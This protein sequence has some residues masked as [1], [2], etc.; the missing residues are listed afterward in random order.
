MVSRDDEQLVLW[1]LY[2]DKSLSRKQGRRVSKKQAVEKPTVDAIAKAASSLKLH[3]TVEKTAVHPSQ[4]F[5]ATGRVLVDAKNA[6]TE[7]L[8]QIAKLL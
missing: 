8:E 3:P 7:V 2:F 4:P 5:K 6:K 1:P